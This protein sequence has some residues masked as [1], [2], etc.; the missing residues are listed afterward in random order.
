[1]WSRV[2][3]DFPE[4]FSTQNSNWY[5]LKVLL[6]SYA[7]HFIL[8]TKLIWHQFYGNPKN[9]QGSKDFDLN[10]NAL[11]MC[12]IPDHWP[13]VRVQL[14]L[15]ERDHMSKILT[16]TNQDQDQSK[17]DVMTIIAHRHVTEHH[18]RRHI[19][20]K[21]N[22]SAGLMR[23]VCAPTDTAENMMITTVPPIPDLL[24]QA[25]RDLLMNF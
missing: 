24:D 23:K 19:T 11:E 9:L 16:T 2:Y 13:S 22:M 17:N 14:P 20:E 3:F 8:T 25:T 21:D 15:L 7:G 10:T 1:M 18:H 12:L 4:Y 6:R 5:L